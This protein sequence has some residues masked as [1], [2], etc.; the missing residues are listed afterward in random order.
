[1]DGHNEVLA[2]SQGRKQ[3]MPETVTDGRRAGQGGGRRVEEKDKQ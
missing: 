3:E 1:M 2:K